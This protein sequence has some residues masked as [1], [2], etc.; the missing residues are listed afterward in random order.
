MQEQG[1]PLDSVKEEYMRKKEEAGQTCVMIALNSRVVAVMA[2]A[3][4]LKPEAKGV[5][6][7]L[8]HKVSTA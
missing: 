2:V 7:A 6:A 8:Q 3:D 5:V 1:V 4:P